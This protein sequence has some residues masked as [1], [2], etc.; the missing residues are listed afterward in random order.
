VSTT[1]AVEGQIETL[2]AE[3]Q[4]YV[5][6]RSTEI[7]RSNNQL[8]TLRARAEAVG[9]QRLQAQLRHEQD[10]QR[11]LV[12]QG[13]DARVRLAVENLFERVL[14]V[15]TIQHREAGSIAY[16]LRIVRQYVGDLLS[17]VGSSQ[18]GQQLQGQ[19]QQGQQQQGQQQQ[20]QQQ[21]SQQG[22]QGAAA[23]SKRPPMHQSGRHSVTNRHGG[24]KSPSVASTNG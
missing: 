3:M 21:P 20:G 23:A 22:Q 10:V 17:M 4:L 14:Q 15:S 1:A 16:Q 24:A 7:L 13:E 18:M 11:A 2:R 5:R 12:G 19:Q 9:K 8:A 6:E